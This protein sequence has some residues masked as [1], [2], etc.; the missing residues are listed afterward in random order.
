MTKQLII[1]KLG[2]S[3]ITNKKRSRPVPRVET[4]QLLAKQV[5]KLYASGKY[6]LI[7]V[8]GAGSFG[9]PLA[10]KYQL[11]Q[12][13]YTAQQRL[14]FGYTAKAMLDLNNILVSKLLKRSLPAVTLPPRAF[15][16]Q[17]GG[18]L[19]PFNYQLI[20]KLL[21]QGMLPVLFGDVVLDNNLG[22][23]ILSGDKIVAFLARKL[24]AK[25]VIFLSDVD[26]IFNKDP[27]KFPDA[28]LIPQINNS[29]IDSV[30]AQL[31]NSNTKDVTGGMKGKILSIQETL[32]GIE[33]VITNGLKNGYLQKSFENNRIA[34]TL[35][36]N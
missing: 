14:G 10:L 25:K 34:T 16:Q 18:S 2:G 29:N 27:K 30:I 12:G 8:H 17:T 28:A 32:A 13:M 6:S 3:V 4:I 11:H 24:A 21:E 1:I 23:S 15:T 31:D 19:K 35:L 9:H 33:V 7:I 36:L 5:Q 22:C 20:R 26:G